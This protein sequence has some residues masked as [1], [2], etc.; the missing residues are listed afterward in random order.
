[1][2]ANRLRQRRGNYSVMLIVALIALL[3]FGALAVDTAQMRAAQ[4]QAQDVADAAS[5]AALIALRHTGSTTEAQ[6]AAQKIVDTNMVAG[7]AAELDTIN[8]GLWDIEGTSPTLQT[9]A[10]NP[11]AVRVRVSREGGNSVPLQLARIMGHES[12]EVSAESTSATR[13]LQVILVM[14]ITNSWSE[15]NFLEARQASELALEMLG[16]TVTPHDEVGMTVFTNR[17]AWEYTPLTRIAIASNYAEVAGD[18]SILNTASKAGTDTN[19]SDGKNCTVHTGTKLNNF[20]SPLGGCYSHMP[21]EWSDEPGTDHSTGILLARQ[22]FE[23]SSSEASYRAMII[24]TDGQPNGLGAPGTKRAAAGYTE[25]RWSEYVG[26]APRTTNQIRNAGVDAAQDLWEDM[27][28]HSWVVSFV[29]DD[30]MMNAMVTG[31]GHYTRTSKA[32]ELEPIFAQII[33][34]MPLA[35]VE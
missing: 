30:W 9:S 26:P 13:S 35:I 28:V 21:R 16:N 3:S 15:K 33:S 34:E 2:L 27:E 22:M 7:K 25:T 10:A 24:L 18:W 31:D 4:A 1:M 20:N 11:N 29:A 23:E 17:F 32:S 14:D 19:K 6:A 8:F 12:F 5:Q